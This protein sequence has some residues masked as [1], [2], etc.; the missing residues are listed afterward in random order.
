MTN[1]CVYT[2]G[3]TQTIP[4]HSSLFTQVVSAIHRNRVLWVTNH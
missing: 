3:G 4:V 1:N 2:L